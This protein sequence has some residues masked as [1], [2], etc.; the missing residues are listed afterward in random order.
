MNMI[1]FD[2]DDLLAELK[3]VP[4]PGHMDGLMRCVFAMLEPLI[5]E[6]KTLRAQVNAIEEKGIRFCGTYQRAMDYQRGSVVISGGSSWVALKASPHGEPGTS[7][8]WALMAK[9]G[10]DAR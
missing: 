1:D 2:T 5:H 10:R 7:P 6:V 4:V 9:A 3:G 8:D